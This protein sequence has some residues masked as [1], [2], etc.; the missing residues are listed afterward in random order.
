M[1]KGGGGAV[2]QLLIASLNRQL[3]PEELEKLKAD[4]AS[5]TIDVAYAEALKI[6]CP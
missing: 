1:T 6:G 5:Y 2:R 3:S 4:G